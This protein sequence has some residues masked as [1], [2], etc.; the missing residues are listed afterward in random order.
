[1]FKM[2]YYDHQDFDWYDMEEYD[3]QD[4]DEY[5]NFIEEFEAFKQC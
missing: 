4:M 3:W 5:N 2:E 1:M